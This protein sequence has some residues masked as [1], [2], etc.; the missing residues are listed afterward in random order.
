M[1][2]E[3]L[4]LDEFSM[5]SEALVLCKASVLGE[6]SM[7]G[8]ILMLND[9]SVLNASLALSDG[10]VEAS[11]ISRDDAGIDVCVSPVNKYACSNKNQFTNHIV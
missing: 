3:V 7:S 9:A 6:V 2:F 5:L 10:F 1:L 11:E 4:V 8:E